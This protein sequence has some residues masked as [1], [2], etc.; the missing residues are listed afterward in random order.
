MAQAP[1]VRVRLSAEG[2]Q[3]VV[4]AFKRIQVEAEKSGRGAGRAL[5]F[6]TGQAAALG[7]LL[8]TLS[9]AAVA[10]GAT[11]LTKRA[12]ENA[13]ALGKLEQKTGLTVKTLSTLSFAARTADLDQEQLRATLVKFTKVTDDYD[14]GLRSARDAVEQ[15]FGTSKALEGLDQDTR[16]LKVVDAL[17]KLEPGAKRTGL[18]MEFFGKQGAELLPLIDDLADGGFEKLRLKAEKLGL[19]VN[20]ELVDAAQ[21]ANDAMTDLQSSAEGIAT[22]FTAGFAPALADV[23]DS[24]V[25]AAS[26]DAVNAFRTL[27]DFAG[28]VLKSIIVLLTAVGAGLVKIVGRTTALI[29]HGGRLVGNVLQG[30]IRQG[31][32]DFKNG[33]VTDADD[34]DRKIEERVTRIFQALDGQNRE[35]SAQRRRIRKRETSANL[36]DCERNAKAERALQ[37]QLLENELNLLKANLKAQTAEEKRRFEEGLIGLQEFFANRRSIIE[38]EAE[39]EIEVLEKRLQFEHARPLAK[40][41]TE[42]DRQKNIAEIENQIAIR[43]IELQEQLADLAAEKRKAARGLQKEQTAFEVK[44]AEMQGNRF[45]AARAALDE[46]A[47]KL[48]EI[49]RK[50]GVAD[51][52]SARRVQEF[53]AAGEAQINFDE[54][55]T[56]GR[57]ALAQIEADRR[58]VELQVQ[59]G[60][61]FQF[62][63]EQQIVALERERLPLLRQIAQ[64]LLAAAE[65]TGDPEKIAQA[66]E[67]AQSI[68]ALAVSSNRAAQEMAQFK[69]SVEQALTSSLQNFFTQGIENAESFGDAMR[70]LALSVVDSLRQI[71]AQMLANLAIQKLLGA[72]GGFGLFSQGGVVKAAGGGLIRGPGTGTSDSIPARLS[73]HEFVVRAA[74]VRQP[75]VL[76]F[77]SE[78]NADGSLVLRRRG[79]RGFAEGGL[80][81]VGG[82]GGGNGSA[83]LTIGLE[84]ELVLKKL[85]ASPMWSR[86][87]VRTLENNRKSVNNA[88]GRGI[89]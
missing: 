1:D 52:E 8:P 79:V 17:A 46:E 71:A 70:Q 75:G 51:A 28:K 37:E 27:G 43:R 81:E 84:P 42:T 80:V 76:E 68:E 89:R 31:W 35:Q 86:V 20:R 6:L 56:Q 41:E 2:V 64:Q 34:L 49:L 67:F 32:E 82:T 26:G 18:A 69:G 22:Q 48:D 36:Q 14:Q 38:Q 57:Q 72:F 40:T 59:Q 12:L 65:A 87:I 58:D 33:I 24:L 19:V 88:L 3:E 66:R 85:E 25:E 11:V 21:R 39:K 10:A 50:Q 15:L 47:W 53:R 23:A 44:L 45:A 55:L 30:N 77:L 9:F 62:Q 4:N 7:R 63:G 73:D 29:V 16:F 61:L 60:I 54:V 5:N 74:V 13:D 78:L 83:D